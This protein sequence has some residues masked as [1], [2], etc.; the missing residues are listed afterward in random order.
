MVQRMFPVKLEFCGWTSVL[1]S[2]YKTTRSYPENHSMNS[3]CHE[4]FKPSDWLTKLMALSPS[5]VLILSQ[6]NPVR[7]T[8]ISLSL[9]SILLLSTHRSLGLPSGLF[10]SGFPTNI[11]YVFFFYAFV[12]HALP[13][14]YSFTVVTLI[15]FGEE[16]KLRSS[17]L[18]NFL[19][20][21]VT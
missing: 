10:P 6:I 19:Q 12:L 11:L 5:L 1:V 14:S 4:N 17:S 21:P 15:I 20:T 16:Y 13:I 9:R 18:C 3:Y 7:T 8:S 2:S